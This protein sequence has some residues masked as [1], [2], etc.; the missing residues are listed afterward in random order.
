MVS[1]KTSDFKLQQE[2]LKFNDIYVSWSSPRIDLATNLF[3]LKIVENVSFSPQGLFKV[4]EYP[5]K[6]NRSVLKNMSAITYTFFNTSLNVPGPIFFNVYNLPILRSPNIRKIKVN[7]VG[8]PINCFSYFISPC[9]N[10]IAVFS[11][12]F[13]TN[14]WPTKG[15]IKPC[16]RFFS[17][18]NSSSYCKK[19]NNSK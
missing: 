8:P 2:V 18:L 10:R 12:N 6:Q 9:T 16:R 19:K 13:F 14:M 7:N 5:F 15:K 3:N 1:F 4:S 17:F 11:N